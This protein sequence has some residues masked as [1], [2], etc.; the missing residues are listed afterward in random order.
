[1]VAAASGPKANGKSPVQGFFHM[2][3]GGL[4]AFGQAYDPYMKTFARA[5]LELMGLMS[6]RAQAYMEIPARLSRC[7][8]PQD[9]AN[10]Q[11]E[12]WRTAFEEYSGSMGRMTDAFASV[13]PPPYGFALPDDD[14]ADDHDYISFP[15]PKEFTR[16]GRSRD[17]KAA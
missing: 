3:F 11:M 2:Y 10:E 15:E 13:A 8:S 16:T 12:F 17:R 4:E 14:V 1:M 7:R 5:Q 6:R 9:V